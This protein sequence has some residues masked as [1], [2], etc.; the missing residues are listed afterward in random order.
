MVLASRAQP[1]SHPE[2]RQRRWVHRRTPYH[3]RM[4]DENIESSGIESNRSDSEP[5]CV[6]VCLC[7]CVCVTVTVTMTVTVCGWVE[8]RALSVNSCGNHVEKHWIKND[9]NYEHETFLSISTAVPHLSHLMAA[10]SVQWW[11]VSVCL[12]VCA[13]VWVRIVFHTA[14][15][16]FRSLVRRT[17]SSNRLSLGVIVVQ[18]TDCSISSFRL[19]PRP[20]SFSHAFFWPSRW[21]IGNR[22]IQSHWQAMNVHARPPAR[23]YW[24]PLCKWNEIENN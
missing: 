21:F 18:N 14:F 5:R 7:L 17:F 6:W 12:C 20:P 11:S 19:L 24:T 10:H 22:T 16:V 15:P 2:R 9:L 13:S 23:A 3:F 4:R 8:W 1:A